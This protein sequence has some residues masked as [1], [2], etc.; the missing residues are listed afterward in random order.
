MSSSC[1]ARRLIQL[2]NSTRACSF[3]EQRGWGT[4][5]SSIRG[6]CAAKLPCLTNST[7]QPRAA[8]QLTELARLSAGGYTCSAMRPGT[9]AAECGHARRTAC[10]ARALPFMPLCRRCVLEVGELRIQ[11]ALE[12]GPRGAALDVGR[13]ALVTAEQTQ[14]TAGPLITVVIIRSPAVKR[15]PSR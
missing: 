1:K 4:L 9:Y 15:S 6:G 7:R 12:R 10:S 5:R 2:C 14:T 13:E 8:G 3:R 11:R